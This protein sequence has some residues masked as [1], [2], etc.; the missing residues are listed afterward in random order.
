VPS[1]EPDGS[2]YVPT[3]V[4]VA[5]RDEISATKASVKVAENDFSQEHTLEGNESPMLVV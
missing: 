2:Q 4:A 3:A 5:R 1:G